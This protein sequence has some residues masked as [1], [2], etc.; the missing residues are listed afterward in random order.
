L[1]SCWALDITVIA[2]LA[3]ALMLPTL[4][5]R[6]SVSAPLKLRPPW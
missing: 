4:T 5:V 6:L 3:R 1:A 2:T